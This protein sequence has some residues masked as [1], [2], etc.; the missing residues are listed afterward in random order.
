MVGR[1]DVA[2]FLISVELRD[3]FLGPLHDP[4]D[5][6]DVLHVFLKAT[7]ELSTD[8]QV[9]E[10]AYFGVRAVRVASSVEA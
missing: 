1:E 5:D 4:V 8:Q 6:L 10:K 2:G 7:D 3:E 9:K